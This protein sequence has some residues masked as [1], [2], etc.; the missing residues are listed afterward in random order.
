MVLG[1]ILPRWM[2]GTL[3][4]EIEVWMG[5]RLV[6]RSGVQLELELGEA[7]DRGVECTEWV[8]ELKIPV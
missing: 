7:L 8:L 1:G 5:S 2:D 4:L 6:A 3:G